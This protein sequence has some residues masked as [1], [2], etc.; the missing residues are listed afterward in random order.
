M[1]ISVLGTGYLGATLA[2]C[3]SSL[4]HAVVGIDNDADRIRE[5]RRGRAPFHEAGVDRLLDEGVRSGRL[6]F[7][8]DLAAAVG[9]DV[10]FLC[11]GTPQ[12][13]NGSR[14]DL[15]ALWAVTHGL[16][17][18]LDGPCLVVGKSTVPVGTAALLR[19]AIHAEAPAGNRVSLAWN[20]EFLR[21]GRAVR[22][23]LEPD[24][25]VVGVE[26]DE[27]LQVL[28]EV[29]ADLVARGVPLIRTDLPTAEL[30]KVAANA[31]LAARLS[32]VNFL[33]EVCEVSAADVGGLTEIL[34]TDP[35]IGHDFLNPGLGYGGGCLPKDTRAF[36][37]RAREL[38][39]VE[40]T[41]LLEA[42]D[43]VNNRQRV[44]TT[45]LAISLLDDAPEGRLV[46][47]L[48]G[49]F[50]AESDD[51]RDS[52]ALEV[53]DRLRDSGAV[54]RVYDPQAGANVRRTH[55]RLQVMADVTAACSGAEL[56]LV[57]TEWAEFASLDPVALTG[58]VA[59]PRV[60]DGRLVL[61]AD[62]W[63]SAGWDFHALGRAL[64]L[65][66]TERSSA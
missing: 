33:A 2:A 63:I 20:P 41:S 4:G 36:V 48:G 17:P 34:G 52:P 28:R 26:S 5:L 42:V 3:L 55:P 22:D 14:A 30:A 45:E 8:D 61:D 32:L 24:R 9:A 49:A 13:D 31:M 16:A 47:V 43:A 40:S 62:K 53:A 10:H 66:R 15:S 27:D 25:L 12:V 57:L 29:Y 46:A 51:V 58:V 56:V 19:D 38:G 6:S 54:V 39:V 60:I 35:R 65:K 37:A 1:L 7:T 44:R 64:P 59:R 50:K 23:S 18:L 11:V 21:E